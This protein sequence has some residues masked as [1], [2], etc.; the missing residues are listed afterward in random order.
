M[1]LDPERLPADLAET[2]DWLAD[3]D[4]ADVLAR[5]RANATAQ[6]QAALEHALVARLLARVHIPEVDGRNTE[7]E[8]QREPDIDTAPPADHGEALYLYGV[9]SADE[10]PPTTVAGVIPGGPIETVAH[11]GLAAVVSRVPLSEFGDEH[12][13]RNLERMEWLERT[14]RGHEAVIENVRAQSTMIPMRMCTLFRG[15]D[16]VCEMLAREAEPLADALGRLVGRSEWGVKALA[17]VARI[18]VALSSKTAPVTPDDDR[19]A[20]R[21]YLEGRQ[22]ERRVAR[23]V[24]R[25]LHTAISEA[26]ETLGAAAAMS[27]RNPLQ[28]PELSGYEDEMVLNGVYLIADAAFDRFRT[29][30][31][32]LNERYTPIGLRLELTGPWPPYNFVS[33]PEDS[34]P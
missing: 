11:E 5:A 30:V 7:P 3:A 28:S 29:R 34:R 16:S 14:A 20:G 23:E 18:H 21:R 2:L 17:D 33:L 25:W 9:V 27:L 6:V 1:S 13:K 15:T 24:D 22:A 4:A 12:L 8:A 31:D 10:P 32:E 26:H 19:E